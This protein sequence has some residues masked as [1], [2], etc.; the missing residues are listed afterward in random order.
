MAEK[1]PGAVFDYSKVGRQWQ[2][3]FAE[4]ADQVSKIIVMAERPLR[5]QKADESD[6]AYDEYV[7]GIYD[8]KEHMGEAIRAQGKIQANL[9]A[10]VLVSV[11]REWLLPDAPEV[12]DWCNPDNLDLIQVSHYAD[13]L[14]LVRSGEAMKKAKK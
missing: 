5:R 14:E 11:P 2:D 13:L 7:Q 8:Q 9:M 10:Q 1:N 3:Q 4:T 12:I 6:E